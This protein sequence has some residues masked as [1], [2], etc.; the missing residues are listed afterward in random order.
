M[1]IS[2]STILGALLAVGAGFLF[3]SSEG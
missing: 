1:L 2:M 3:R